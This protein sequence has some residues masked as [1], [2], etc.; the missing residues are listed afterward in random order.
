MTPKL[1]TPQEAKAHILKQGKTFK[2]IAKDIGCDYPTVVAVLNGRNHGN[3][4][5]AH[6]AA[7][8][9]GIKEAA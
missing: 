2:E 3:F 1:L 6:K 8:A 5:K 4:G 7:V 9:L